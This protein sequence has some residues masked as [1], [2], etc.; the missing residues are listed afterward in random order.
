MALETEEETTGKLLGEIEDRRLGVHQ[1]IDWIWFVPR[2]VTFLLGFLSLLIAT[3]PTSGIATFL[4]HIVVT[5]LC[6]SLMI[7]REDSW[8]QMRLWSV[9]ILTLTF[10]TLAWIVQ[11]GVGHAMFEKNIPNVAHASQH[12]SCLAMC[13]SVLIAWS[14]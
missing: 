7:I 1:S 9:S 13:Q 10:W 3:K 5:K 12:V 2:V 8:F 6:D 4:F 14:S 11:V